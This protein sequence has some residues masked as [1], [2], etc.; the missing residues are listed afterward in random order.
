MYG[1][2]ESESEDSIIIRALFFL[3]KTYEEVII[4]MH[5]EDPIYYNSIAS[6][7]YIFV[8]NKNIPSN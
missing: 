5:I 4:K 1:E 3:R 2:R 8:F 6:A 7:L